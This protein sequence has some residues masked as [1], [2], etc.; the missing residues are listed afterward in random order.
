MSTHNATSS[1][2]LLYCDLW[3]PYR[4]PSSCDA[5]YFLTIMDDFSRA[6]WIYL[7]ADKREVVRNP[8]G[9]FLCQRKYSLH[10]IQEAG[11]LG[12]KPISTPLE[13]N[14]QLSL[15]TGCLLDQPVRY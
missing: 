6:I 1:F 14:H 7:L 11:L 12:T 4:T 15:A 3:G 2:D 8:S 5:S 10:I 13:Q 9:I